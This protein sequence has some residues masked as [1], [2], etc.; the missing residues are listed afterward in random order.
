MLQITRFYDIMIDVMKAI[1]SFLSGK[2]TYIIGSLMIALGLLTG[3]NQMVLEGV[4]FITLRSAV[5]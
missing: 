1:I 5:G 2:K 3:N 4:G